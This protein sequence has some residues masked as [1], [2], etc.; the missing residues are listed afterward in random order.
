MISQVSND[1]FGING[2]N[3]WNGDRQF[4]DRGVWAF[5]IFDSL[6]PFWCECQ[7]CPILC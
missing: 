2:E 4:S 7:F 1:R 6:H 3:F 5:S